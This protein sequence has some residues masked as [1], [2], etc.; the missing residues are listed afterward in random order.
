MAAATA[1][2]NLQEVAPGRRRALPM[3]AAAKVF[4]GTIAV[5]DASGNCNKGITSTAV[6]AMGVFAQPYDNTA[7]AAGAITAEVDRGIFGPFANSSAGDL[8]GAADVGADCYIV[9]D[10]TVA[11]T[12]GSSTRS[13][14]GKVWSVDA[15]G[16]YVEFR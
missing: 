2:R 11:K 14:A 16:V 4:Q 8:I 13:I 5:I 6:R 15:S 1:N 9:D 10:Q 7:G 3:A 12:S